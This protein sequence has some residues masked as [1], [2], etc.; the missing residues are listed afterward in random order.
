M[1]LSHLLGGLYKKWKEMEFFSPFDGLGFLRFRGLENLLF[2]FS[3]FAFACQ[4]FLDDVAPIQKRCY[5]PDI[6]ELVDFR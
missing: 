2:L 3:F 5:M 1:E 6:K 4:D